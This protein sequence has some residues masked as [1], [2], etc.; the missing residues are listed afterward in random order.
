[1]F[2]TATITGEPHGIRY[3]RKL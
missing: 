3:D 1:M 2:N